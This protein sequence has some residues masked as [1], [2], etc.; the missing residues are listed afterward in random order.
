MT[1]LTMVLAQGPQLPGGDVTYK[2]DVHLLLTPQGQINLTAWEADPAPW[3][4]IR[5]WPGHTA[6]RAEVIRLDEG[7]ALQSLNSE[8]DP[9]WTFDGE[10]FRPG[11]LVRVGRPDGEELLFRIVA[12]EGD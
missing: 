12:A 11:E 2:L 9:L 4:A 6:R 10:V 1:K 3:L 5:E 7:W 8:D